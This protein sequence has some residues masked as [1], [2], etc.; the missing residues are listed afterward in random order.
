MEKTDTS[1]DIIANSQHTEAAQAQ[2][3]WRPRHSAR[4]EQIQ[5]S[6]SQTDALTAQLEQNLLLDEAGLSLTESL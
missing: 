5:S 6:F 3:A 2:S 1:E 4:I